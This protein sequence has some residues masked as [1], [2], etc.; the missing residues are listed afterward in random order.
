MMQS[1][2]LLAKELTAAT[3]VIRDKRIENDSKYQIALLQSQTQLLMQQAK[4]EG[5]AGLAALQAQLG[6]ISHLMEQIHT[7][8]FAEEQTPN[9]EQPPTVQA[10]APQKPDLSQALLPPAPVQPGVNG[11]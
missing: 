3:A 5:E 1:H 8:L 9:P 2:D 7:Q 4:T 11:Q 6:T 10:P